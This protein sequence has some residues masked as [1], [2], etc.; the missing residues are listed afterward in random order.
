[1]T[2]KLRY[3]Q[4]YQMKTTIIVAQNVSHFMSS[5]QGM[6]FGDEY[7]AVIAY[8]VFKSL[9]YSMSLF[10]GFLADT[11]IGKFNAIMVLAVISLTGSIT[12]AQ[13]AG[14]IAFSKMVNLT[15]ARALVS[16]GSG[17]VSVSDVTSTE[18][19]YLDG[20]SSAIQTQLDTKAAKSFAI[21][22]AVALG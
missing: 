19:G 22:Q 11:W 15:N 3:N 14:S 9:T 8:H 13:L 5:I 16:D 2:F 17:D 1:M 10:G 18:I 6:L 20:V 7:I 12:N 4:I 21:A